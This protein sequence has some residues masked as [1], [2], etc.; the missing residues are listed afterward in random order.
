MSLAQ[1]I[2]AHIRSAKALNPDARISDFQV[3]VSEGSAVLINL[4]TGEIKLIAADKSDSDPFE[5]SLIQ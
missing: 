1:K 3:R 2:G 4:R 5:Q